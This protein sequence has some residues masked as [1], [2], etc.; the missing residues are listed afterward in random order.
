MQ[1]MDDLQILCHNIIG[2]RQTHQLTRQEM[3]D[4]M[5]ISVG[6]LVRIEQYDFPKEIGVNV[7]FRLENRFRCSVC[8]LLQKDF[9]NTQTSTPT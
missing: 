6:Q 4:I 7:L 3:A 8:K 5:H 2:L 9:G 1:K